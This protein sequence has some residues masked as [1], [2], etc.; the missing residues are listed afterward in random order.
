AAVPAGYA[1]GSGSHG[2]HQTDGNVWEYSAT[3][4]IR[5]DGRTGMLSALVYTAG[6]TYTGD[7]CDLSRRFWASGRYC[8]VVPVGTAQVGVAAAADPVIALDQWA[9]Y[10]QPAGVVV[11]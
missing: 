7:P 4:T 1:V 11:C 8:Q 2:A 5:R 9:V 6:N 10:R 3:A